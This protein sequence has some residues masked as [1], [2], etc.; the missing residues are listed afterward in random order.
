MS[1]VPAPP[2]PS[3][4]SDAD[5]RRETDTLLARIEATT[6]RW[7]DDDVVAIDTVMLRMQ[8]PIK[9][10]I[11][12]PGEIRRAIEMIYHGS[13]IEERQIRELIATENDDGSGAVVALSP[14][15]HVATGAAADGRQPQLTA[16]NPPIM[17]VRGDGYHALTFRAQTNDAGAEATLGFTGFYE[18]ED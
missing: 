6:D 13:D 18:T 16:I 5:Y 7:L 15:F 4:L 3:T 17:V 9:P 1:T 10:V 2:A 11:G 8:R 14:Q 12:A